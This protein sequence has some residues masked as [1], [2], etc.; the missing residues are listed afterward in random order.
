MCLGAI[1]WA[2]PAIVYY[3]NT[4]NDAAA[5]GFDDAMIYKEMGIDP[6]Y[7]KIP[8]VNLCRTEA[9]KAFVQ[10]SNKQDNTLY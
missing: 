6:E 1:Y 7:R 8:V 5:I 9:F 10:W 3:G 2:R 4:R